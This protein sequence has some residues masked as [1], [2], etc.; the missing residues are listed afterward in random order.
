MEKSV[1][2]KEVIEEPIPSVPQEIKEVEPVV[3][4]EVQ[5]TQDAP[6]SKESDE[7]AFLR[8]LYRVQNDGGFGIHLNS[9]INDRIEYLKSK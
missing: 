3:E 7:I 5:K 9:I 6:L 8:N 2:F 1:K 4:K